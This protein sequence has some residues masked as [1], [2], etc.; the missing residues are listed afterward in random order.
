MPVRLLAELAFLRMVFGL[1]SEN[2]HYTPA[3]LIQGVGV[4][5]PN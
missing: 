2:G 5:L 3:R 1:A 4:L